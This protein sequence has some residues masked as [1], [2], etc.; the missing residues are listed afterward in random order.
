MSDERYKE[1][2]ELKHLIRAELRR[3]DWLRGIGV[4]FDEQGPHIKVNVATE[5]DRDK[6]TEALRGIAARTVIE[7][8]GDV[9]AVGVEEALKQWDSPLADNPVAQAGF[10]AGWAAVFEHM[11]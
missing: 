2:V 6:A 9:E 3:P 8:L 4:G 7:V 11:V 1:L 10:R 5:A